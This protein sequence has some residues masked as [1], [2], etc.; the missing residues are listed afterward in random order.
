VEE[1]RALWVVKPSSPDW[2]PFGQILRLLAQL[3]EGSAQDAAIAEAD[4]AMRGLH[5]DMPPKR[6]N[7]D[8]ATSPCAT[9][10]LPLATR[11]V[12]GVSSLTSLPAMG[13]RA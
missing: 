5:D 1:L 13:M 2:S 3:S 8:S 9:S 11:A 7:A 10:S 6:S 12:C 4:R